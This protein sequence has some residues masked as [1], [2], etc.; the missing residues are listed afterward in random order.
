M[1]IS[2]LVRLTMDRT[3]VDVLEISSP[4]KIS[5]RLTGVKEDYFKFQDLLRMFC[6]QNFDSLFKL[7]L[8]EQGGQCLLRRMSSWHRGVVLNTQD[9]VR[10]DFLIFL[11]LTKL[12]ADR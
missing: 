9:Q 10:G 4:E 6:T 12:A 11:S 5:V 1:Q 7:W 8:P 2:E 3:F